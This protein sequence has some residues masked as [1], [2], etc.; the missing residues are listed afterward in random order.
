[1]TA[2]DRSK[3]NRQQPPQDLARR[4]GAPPVEP[5]PRAGERLGERGR[6]IE[7]QAL[8]GVGI[9]GAGLFQRGFH[10]L[11]PGFGTGMFA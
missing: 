2:P 5:T 7:E 10:M 6:D 11:L 1:M 4:V 3:K 8:G 9:E